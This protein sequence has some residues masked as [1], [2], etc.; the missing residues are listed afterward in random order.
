M[1][2]IVRSSQLYLSLCHKMWL[3]V[4]DVQVPFSLKSTLSLVKWIICVDTIGIYYRQM[5]WMRINVSS[6][7]STITLFRRMEVDL[8][9]DML[10]FGSVPFSL[11]KKVLDCLVFLFNPSENELL[12][13]ILFC[14][15]SNVIASSLSRH[16]CHLSLISM[17]LLVRV[18]KGRWRPFS[19]RSMLGN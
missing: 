19:A 3:K 5:S 11:K 13:L 8:R 12:Q 15:I 1:P 2:C 14:I 9:S 16:P 7:L 18:A 6:V 4:G 17:W 10:T